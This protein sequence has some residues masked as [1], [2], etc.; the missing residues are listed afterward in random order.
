AVARY[1]AAETHP[2]VVGFSMAGD[3]ANF[4]I[5]DFA[6]AYAIAADAGLGCTVHAG[7]W[8][9]PES[10]RAPDAGLGRPA[11]LRGDDRRR[12]RGVR[13]AA[14]LHRGRSDRDHAD[15]DRRRLLR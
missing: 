11:L 14:R 8:A 15:R 9:G 7:E 13:R 1:A 2:Y 12:V 4:P 10:V 6:A 5:S 3:E